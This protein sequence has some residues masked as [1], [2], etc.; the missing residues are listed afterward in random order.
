[1]THSLVSDVTEHVA[2]KVGYW[3]TSCKLKLNARL[4]TVLLDLLSVTRHAQMVEA[5]AAAEGIVAVLCRFKEAARH[6]THS[7]C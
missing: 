2:G 3:A 4:N 6:S 7:E 1:M 5:G